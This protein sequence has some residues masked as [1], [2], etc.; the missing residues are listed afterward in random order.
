MKVSMFYACIEARFFEYICIFETE[1]NLPN[2]NKKCNVVI[3]SYETNYPKKALYSMLFIHIA[4]Q[5]CL[6]VI[7]IRQ[8]SFKVV[9]V[10]ARDDRNMASTA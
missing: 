7:S 8:I 10:I 4:H 5:C 2:A 6:L 3:V 9:T 1:P